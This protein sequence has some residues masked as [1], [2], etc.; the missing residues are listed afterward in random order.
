MMGLHSKPL[1]EGERR[2]VGLE[3]RHTWNRQAEASPPP[4]LIGDAMVWT[5]KYRQ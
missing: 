2:M 5:K 3:D 4:P 1:H